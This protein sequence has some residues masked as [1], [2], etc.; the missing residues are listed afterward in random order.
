MH[1]GEAAEAVPRPWAS[2]RSGSHRS[3]SRALEQRGTADA[4]LSKGELLGHE[5]EQH[6][7][8]GVAENAVAGVPEDLVSDAPLA[9]GAEDDDLGVT[10]RGFFEDG[11]A[12]LWSSHDV[13]RELD[14]EL[15]RDECRALRVSSALA[16]SRVCSASSGWFSGTSITYRP[17]IDDIFSVAS[18]Q[19]G[20]MDPSVT[21]EPTMGTSIWW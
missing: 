4:R 7:A 5:V 3:G 12:G 20:S 17:S 6:L 18:W 1:A 21:C 13:R 10:E 16:C 19:A 2:S 11:P 9:H 8:R 15:R 14:L